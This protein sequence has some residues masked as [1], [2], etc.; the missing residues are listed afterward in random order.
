[1]DLELYAFVIFV[2]Q[3]TPYLMGKQFTV[4]TNKNNL[5]YLANSLIP[6]LVCWRVF[7]SKFRFLIHHIPGAQNVVSD[8]LGSLVFRMEIARSK[9]HIFKEN[10]ILHIFR[11]GGEG[12]MQKGIPGE[13]EGEDEGG[14]SRVR[15]HWRFW[16]TWYLCKISQFYRSESWRNALCRTYCWFLPMWS[17]E[18]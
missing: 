15:R 11:F 9:S 16:K 7:F 4:N 6:K 5:A 12:M 14:R 1:M 18:P 10:L 13:I 8:G 17:G 2:K 3:L